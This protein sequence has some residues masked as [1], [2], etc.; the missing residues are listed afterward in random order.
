MLQDEEK[1]IFYCFWARDLYLSW[2]LNSGDKFEEQS[3][4][5]LESKEGFVCYWM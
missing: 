3:L 5:C 4:V 1:N 2:K